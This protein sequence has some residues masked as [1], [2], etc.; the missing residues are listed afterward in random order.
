MDA[1][2][3]GLLHIFMQ[4]LPMDAPFYV[5]IRIGISANFQVRFKNL[6]GCVVFS[7]QACLKGL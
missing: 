1:A 7:N 5:S 6:K 3:E 2:E 4:C